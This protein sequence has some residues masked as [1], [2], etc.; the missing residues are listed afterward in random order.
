MYNRVIVK[1]E[2]SFFIKIFASYVALL[3]VLL[4]MGAV[5]YVHAAGEIKEQIE[6]QGEQSLV[7]VEKAFSAEFQNVEMMLTQ[8]SM[9]PEVRS[10]MLEDK[11]NDAEDAYRLKQIIN[12]LSSYSLL[13]DFIGNY[14]IWFWK[15]DYVVTRSYAYRSDDFF[16]LC[17]GNSGMS[18][19]QWEASKKERTPYVGYER[20]VPSEFEGSGG[21]NVIEYGLS[22]PLGVGPALGCITAMVDE[23][24]VQALLSQSAPWGLCYAYIADNRGNIVSFHGNGKQDICLPDELPEGD[25]GYFTLGRGEGRLYLSY[26]RSRDGKWQYVIACSPLE[27]LGPVVR[28][29]NRYLLLLGVLFS[30]SL[31]CV[32]LLSFRQSK[33]LWDIASSLAAKDISAYDLGS[34]K[35][36]V[37][38]L[39]KDNDAIIEERVRQEAMLRSA[40][41]LRLLQGTLT[42]GKHAIANGMER[43]GILASKRY[44]VVLM[45]LEGVNGEDPLADVRL[46]LKRKA[47]EGSEDFRLEAVDIDVR[48]MAFICFS[49]AD[50]NVACDQQTRFWF[51]ELS[52]EME[53]VLQ[54]RQLVVRGSVVDTPSRIQESY[55]QAAYSLQNKLLGGGGIGSGLGGGAGYPLGM[56]MQLV[57]A[58]NEGDL[59]AI[60]AILAN[61]F[62]QNDMFAHADNEQLRLTLAALKNT[63]LRI[64]QSSFGSSA[65]T[66]LLKGQIESI[67]K[68]HQ[69][70]ILDVFGQV[71]AAL[72]VKRKGE[73]EEFSR[74]MLTFVD[75]H[76]LEKSFSLTSVSDHFRLNESYVST[77]FKKHYH[78]NFL[79]YVKKRRLD[80]AARLLRDSGMSVEEIS[81]KTGYS[82]SHSFRRAF[83]ER[84]GISPAEYRNHS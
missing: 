65:D 1:L 78:V 36:A 68:L 10:F 11:M 21:G 52:R 80:E 5:L 74:K 6:S 55:G 53:R 8:I 37:N 56:E 47:E 39:I 13:S 4:A 67:K 25:H 51:G 17:Y 15:N 31:L 66:T 26:A 38:S 46:V 41:L 64:L 16:R 22:I 43:S 3:A 40:F 69:E 28:M 70:E 77:Y 45:H 19:G 75:V 71:S 57:N 23:S 59:D 54:L 61:L 79:M 62:R 2:K 82:T 32:F 73:K 27:M 84:Y 76:C 12:S 34:L 20:T 44:Q 72:V 83:K 60:K 14:Y 58:T 48:T 7:Q 42:L 50:D 24:Q 30:I 33:P 18:Y 81:H 35:E 63:L 29:R 9:R 49:D